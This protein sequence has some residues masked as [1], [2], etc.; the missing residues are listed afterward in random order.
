MIR[1]AGLPQYSRMAYLIKEPD[2]WQGHSYTSRKVTQYLWIK[3]LCTLASVQLQLISIGF[4]LIHLKKKNGID[5]EVD[6]IKQFVCDEQPC[7]QQLNSTDEF[8]FG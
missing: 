6:S 1:C 2:D 3:C 4:D 8:W 5:K 7:E